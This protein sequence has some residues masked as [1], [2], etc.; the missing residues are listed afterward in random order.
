MRILDIFIQLNKR[1]IKLILSPVSY[2]RYLGVTVGD[3]NLMQKNHWPTEPYLITIGSNCQL[4]NCKIHT[5]GGGNVIRNKYPTYDSFGKVTIGDWVYIGT[6]AQIM[7]GVT[8]GNNVLVAAG[9]IVTKSIPSGLVVAGNPARVIGTIDDYMQRNLKWNVESKG[10]NA[11]RK[12]EYLL[13]LQEDK[14]IVRPF[15]EY[16]QK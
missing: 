5:H 2:A 13:S 9:S 11:K 1:I 15:L 6:D 10:F 12:K 16:N 3:N 14:F 4:T 8:I 7:P